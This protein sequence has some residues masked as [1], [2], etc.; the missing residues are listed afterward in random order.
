[1]EK[2]KMTQSKNRMASCIILHK[3]VTTIEWLTVYEG[4]NVWELKVY[5]D[6]SREELI[7]NLAEQF[8]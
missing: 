4:D 2:N 7:R 3:T 1:M 8:I 5:P 6:I